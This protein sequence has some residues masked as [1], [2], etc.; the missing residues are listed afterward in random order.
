MTAS[1]VFR[2]AEKIA[3]RR[4]L[5]KEVH[6]LKEAMDVLSHHEVSSA[7]SVA[8]ILN[9]A[10]PV[11]QTMIDDG[12]IIL[13]TGKNALYFLIRHNSLVK[14]T[15]CARNTGRP[16][17]DTGKKRKPFFPIL[18]RLGSGHLSGKKNSWKACVRMK[19]KRLV[20]S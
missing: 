20:I 11:V 16:G 8:R 10:C 13:K 5:S 2:K 1:H 19:N 15:G 14:F 6:I 17:N 3:I 12:D 4:N 7:K 9:A 18:S